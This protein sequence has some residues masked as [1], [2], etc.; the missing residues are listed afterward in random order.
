MLDTLNELAQATAALT[1]ASGI[2][3]VGLVSTPGK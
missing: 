3:P 1:A 2:P